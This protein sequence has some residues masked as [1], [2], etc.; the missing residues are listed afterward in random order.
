MPITGSR[1]QTQ[2]AFKRFYEEL[3]KS[4]EST[5]CEIGVTMLKWIKR[6]DEKLPDANIY[7]LTSHMHLILMPGETY[8]ED[9]AVKL[10]GRNNYYTVQYLMPRKDSPWLN[11]YITG[12][13]QDFDEAVAMSVRAIQLCGLWPINEL[14]L[15]N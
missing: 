7:G 9:W 12:E 14:R 1:S 5:S 15:K 8:Q 10:M 6:I 11:A 2:G 4:D 3:A 13:F